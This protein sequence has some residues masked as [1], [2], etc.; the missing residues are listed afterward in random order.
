MAGFV[1]DVWRVGPAIPGGDISRLSVILMECS[2]GSCFGS[3]ICLLTQQGGIKIACILFFVFFWVGFIFAFLICSAV[4]IFLLLWKNENY[5]ARMHLEK[6]M[7]C[8]YSESAHKRKLVRK[9]LEPYKKRP[10]LDE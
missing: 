8:V 4:K 10:A 3:T 1:V 7:K 9:E 6:E 2:F 5:Y